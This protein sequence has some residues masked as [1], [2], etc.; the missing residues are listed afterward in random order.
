MLDHFGSS[1]MPGSSSTQP[2][3]PPSAIDGA[4]L[5][6]LVWGSIER[7]TGTFCPYAET[8]EIEAAF[9]RFVDCGDFL[10]PGEIVRKTVVGT[11]VK[12]M[13]AGRPTP[14]NEYMR[15]RFEHE[16]LTMDAGNRAVL[17]AASAQAVGTEPRPQ[18]PSAGGQR[19]RL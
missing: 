18:P 16:K 11:P 14:T 15:L 13:T 17:W 8:A 4:S 9:A 12:C 3:P 10:M 5:G 2:D 6:S 19:S 1:G 7:N